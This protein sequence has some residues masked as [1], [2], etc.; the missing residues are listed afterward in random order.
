LRQKIYRPEKLP[1]KPSWTNAAKTNAAK[2]TAYLKVAAKTN[3]DKCGKKNCLLKNCRK[4]HHGQ[5]RQKK[6]RS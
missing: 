6:H 4:N 5:M 3:M 2:K 1:Q